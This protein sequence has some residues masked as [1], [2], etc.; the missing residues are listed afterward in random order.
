M[1]TNEI[2]ERV[3]VNIELCWDEENKE[4]DWDEYE[5]LCSYADYWDCEE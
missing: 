4:F 3:A 1:K 5:L 2:N